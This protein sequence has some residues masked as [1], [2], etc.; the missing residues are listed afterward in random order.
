VLIQ[1]PNNE[2]QASSPKC[3]Y[4]KLGACRF[5]AQ[6]ILKGAAIV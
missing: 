2:F 6:N 5:K 1:T 4:L 3:F